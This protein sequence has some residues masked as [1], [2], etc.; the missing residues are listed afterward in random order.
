ML[1]SHLLAKK[2]RIL[3]RELAK[4]RF[5]LNDRNHS[6]YGFDKVIA[7]CAGAGFSPR[8]AATA[9]VGSGMIALVEAGEGVAILPQGWNILRGNEV[10]WVP[11]ADRM[12][13]HDL[14]I[15]WA[16]QHEN[17]VLRSFLELVLKKRPKQ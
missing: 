17:P 5:I 4:E 15:A 14:V 2:R 6:P 13:F 8:I 10:A 12:A 7:L 11:L 16:P 9:T 3:I 1:K